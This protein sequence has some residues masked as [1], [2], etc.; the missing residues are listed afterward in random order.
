MRY[1]GGIM[2][3][4]GQYITWINNS[5]HKYTDKELTEKLKQEGFQLWNHIL[6][7]NMRDGSIE[8]KQYQRD[9]QFKSNSDAVF[10]E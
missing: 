8:Y 9:G 6:A 10:A 7:Y 4:E 5:P 3:K 2:S 1:G